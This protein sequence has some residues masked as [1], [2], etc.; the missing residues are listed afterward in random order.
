MAEV[1]VLVKPSAGKVS[2]G[3]L[4]ALTT[5]QVGAQVSGASQV[6]QS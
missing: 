1:L 5:V 2:K 3:T 4:E 6:P